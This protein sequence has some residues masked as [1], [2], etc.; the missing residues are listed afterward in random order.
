MHLALAGAVLQFGA[1]S[2][3]ALAQQSLISQNKAVYASSVTG[4]NTPDQAVDGLLASRWESAYKDPQWLYVD[5]GANASI[6]RVVINWEGAYATAYE[7]Q[8]SDDEVHWSPVYNTTTNHSTTNDIPLAAQGRYV[9]LYGTARNTGYGYS[10]FEFSVYGSGG[11]V[12]PAPPVNVALG[13]QVVASSDESQQPNHPQDLPPTQY[14]AGNITD[15]DGT[16]RWSSAY[17]DN[18]WIYV[19][20]GHSTVIG[21]VGLDWQNAFG[22]AYDIEVSDDASNWTAVYRTLA[23]AGGNELIPLY[24]SGRY[25]RMKGIARATQYGYSLFEFKVY[26]YREG[27][28]KPVYTLPP[29]TG[30]TRVAVGK[31]SYEQGDLS[32]PEPPPPQ[33]KTAAVKGPIP[34][35]DWWQSLLISNLGNGNGLV[36]LPLRSKYTRSGLGVT[37]L[38]GGYATANGIDSG[39]EPDLYI[40]PTNVV[41]ANM[42][43]RVAGYGDYSVDVVM[44]DDDSA[45]MT[46][47]LVQGSPFIY[48]TFANPDKVQITSYGITRLFDSAGNTI[49]DQDVATYQGDMIGVEV[50]GTEQGRATTHW[51]GVFAPAGSTFL[52]VGSTIKVTLGGN[53]N[54][55]SLA[56]MTAPT[57]LADFSQ[58]AYAFVTGTRADYS[59]DP[60]TSQVSTTFQTSTTLKRPGFSADTIMGLLPHQW[61][62]SDAALSWRAFPSVRGQIK[63][64][65]GNTFRTADRF[66][67][68]IPQFSEPR[69]G[70]YSRARLAGFLD[71]LDQSVA[72]NLMN[73]DPYWQGK[74]LHPLAMGVLIADQVGDGA[75]RDRY[76]AKLKT[77][78]SD[79]LSYS[80]DAPHGTY[81][82][83]VKD[84][85][86][87]VA[88]TTGFGLNTGLTDHHFTYGYFTF[89]AAVLGTYDK[90]F[91]T[92][93]GPMVEM[94]L[95]DYGNPSRTD[96]QF[97]YLRNFNAYEGHSWAGGFGDNNSGNN[98]E[99]A[100]EALF[101]WVGMYLWGMVTNNNSYRDA[102]IYGF[103][104]EEKAIEQYW[105]NYDRDSWTPDYGHGVVGQVYGSAYNYG[106]Y[107]GDKPAYIYGIHWLP[108]AEWL[109]YYG[110]DPA[111]AGAL[112]D[113]FVADNYGPE[114]EWQHIIHPFQALSDAPAVLAKF[115]PAQMQ[116][117][118]VFNAYW[119]INSMATLGQR[120]TDIWG[121]NWPAATVY[122]N[123]GAYSAQ[124]WNPS[125][126]ARTVQFSN[127]SGITGSALIPPRST[128]TVDP[129][130]VV[131]TLPDA[132]PPQADPYLDRS[133]W[134]VTAFAQGGAVANMLDGDAGTR[135]T[136]GQTQAPNQWI[137]LDMQ[138]T[139]TFDT[140]SLNAGNG[141]DYAHGYQVYVSADGSSWGQPVLTGADAGQIQVLNLG[142]QTARYIRIVQTGTSPSWWSIAELKVANFGTVTTPPPPQPDPD[143]V[144]PPPQPTGPLDRHLWS[145]TT[146]KSG[147]NDLPLNMADGDR[148]TI[149]SSTT[150]Q[151]PGQW[152]EVDMGESRYLDTVAI[153]AA[154]RNGDAARGVKLF[155]S[156]DGA[157]WGEPVFTA[158][159]TGAAT[160]QQRLSA[161]FTPVKGR[162]LR[163]EQTGS[164][165]NWWA[166]AELTAAYNGTGPLTEIPR[167]GWKLSASSTG[168]GDLPVN[169]IDGQTGTR[170]T[171]GAA[172]QPG[173]WFQID[174]GSVQTVKQVEID[175]ASND[176]ARGYQVLV[177]A[178]GATWGNPVA[179]GVGDG[180]YLTVVLGERQARYVRIVQTGSDNH[181]WSIAEVKLLK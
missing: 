16:T 148:N 4:A 25:V 139:R 146:F 144:P 164:A 131:T 67:G 87:L 64:F 110:R 153:D 93:Y 152:V 170:W 107:F 178:D 55:L 47:T 5:L 30:A 8:V 43:T 34:S 63:L 1:A 119:F 111:K 56:T 40:K 10:V 13:A 37:T 27:D 109:T 171:S 103:T 155:V 7:I 129:T 108:T 105:F 162:H 82:H 20:L 126:V 151:A 85:G 59:Y 121:V 3:P 83:Y 104:T 49:L 166:I 137:V 134:S 19:D 125:D 127:G 112:Y 130:R 66:H 95:R 145:I 80:G 90:A 154:G 22:R 157:A 100:G 88:Y 9:R 133:G 94:L 99:A 21:G 168:G 102:G 76:L 57:D 35:N 69:N 18:E 53:Q 75:R 54:Y 124:V 106:T 41:S 165:G 117:N 181:W 39:G 71:Q 136:S 50:A 24:A 175:A 73:N 120:S 118:E 172:Q 36:T 167:T 72:G 48:N 70:G 58:H 38:G 65:E 98:Q 31:G 115:D 51:Y 116:A 123:G 128:V 17:N 12:V 143:P 122:K 6:S 42:Q 173:Q 92:D 23:S 60:A 180:A 101:S 81:L 174:L 96:A 140:L 176:Y 78:L 28:P 86:S 15:N 77:I 61:K 44:S 150:A 89:A 135:W 141:G 142:K 32:Q 79:W 161:T 62:L 33:F 169:A 114:Q 46:T 45:K 52:R 158:A 132:P 147:N 138:Q 91:V 160:G 84:W 97:P 179:S 29:V 156:E 2:A 14:L 113:S 163:I 11:S 177:S 26:P 68:V 74:A 149:W 159:N